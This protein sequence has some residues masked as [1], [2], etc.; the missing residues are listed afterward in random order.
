MSGA[1]VEVVDFD[2]QALLVLACCEDNF[3]AGVHDSVGDQF[4]G[5]QF[6]GFGQLLEVPLLAAAEDEAAPSAGR[7]RFGWQF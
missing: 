4:A 6:G 3:A 1:A 7:R 2:E 5:E